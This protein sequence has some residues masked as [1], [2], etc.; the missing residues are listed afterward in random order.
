MV[1]KKNALSPLLVS[2]LALGCSRLQSD[3]SGLGVNKEFFAK[4]SADLVPASDKL[5]VGCLK[6]AEYDTC[7]FQKNA[8]AQTGVALT[9]SGANGYR[10]FGIKLR[11]VQFG[12]NLQTNEFRVATLNS[13][14][15]DLR[16][17][18]SLKDPISVS[19]SYGE[20][21]S[22][23]YWATRFTTYLASRLGR[24]YAQLD[25]LTIYVDD[26]MTG[27]V[28]KTNSIH[29]KKESNRLSHAWSGEI[30]QQL[31]A[32]ALVDRLTNGKLLDV[33][34]RVKHKTCGLSARGCCES[35]K[36]CSSA[37]AE[38]FGD[39]L[40]GVLHPGRPVLGEQIGESLSGQ[41]LCGKD[42]DL[43]NFAD[44]SANEAYNLCAGRSGYVA[45]MGMWYASLWWKM[46]LNVQPIGDSALL[47]WDQLFVEHMRGLTE[48]SDF[49][50]AAN[51][52]RSLADSLY[53]GKFK[54]V[55]QEG[56]SG[57]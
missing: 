27:Y 56:L 29:L 41:K 14:A 43:R 48:S 36:G 22:A 23:F 40:A 4:A 21:L 42:R 28:R 35:D 33:N 32:Q 12:A 18:Q 9:P 16:R 26:V 6:T 19:T 7:I 37:L 53:N 52:A 17:P 47:E 49:S 38:S 30:I 34:N 55:I 54:S 13:E 10:M 57:V 25:G 3:K 39:Y 45:V 8:F 24:V 46:R 15:I 20:Q 50:E 2:L 51:R 11:G 44:I 1:S 5:V 31:M